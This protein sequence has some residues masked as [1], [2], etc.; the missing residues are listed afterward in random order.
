MRVTYSNLISS[1]CSTNFTTTLGFWPGAGRIFSGRLAMPYRSLQLV[2]SMSAAKMYGRY[3]V[4]L[5]QRCSNSMMIFTEFYRLNSLLS[6]RFLSR[7]LLAIIMTSSKAPAGRSWVCTM[8][9]NS[10]MACLRSGTSFS[11]MLFT[12]L[13]IWLKRSGWCTSS[14]Y[15]LI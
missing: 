5:L 12:F 3:C 11:F 6:A 13:R 2:L 1:H 14:D 10:R 4:I 9:R 8:R 7:S 15:Y